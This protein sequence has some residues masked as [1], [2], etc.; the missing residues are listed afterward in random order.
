MFH[1]TLRIY[2]QFLDE[3]PMIYGNLVFVFDSLEHRRSRRF[4]FLEYLLALVGL[5]VS[6]IYLLIPQ[7]Y[8]IFLASYSLMLVVVFSRTVRRCCGKRAAVL[9]ATGLESDARYRR[10]HHAALGQELCVPELALLLLWRR[11]LG[12]REHHVPLAAQ[13]VEAARSVARAGRAR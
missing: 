4:P 1:A 2:F 10:A 11:A 9:S 12:A 7:L 3:L 6:L 8:V 5:V 13:V